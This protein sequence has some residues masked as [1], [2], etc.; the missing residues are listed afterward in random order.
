MQYQWYS[1]D[2]N[3]E[4]Y[5]QG[6]FIEAAVAHYRATQKIN[7]GSADP[8]LFNVAWSWADHIVS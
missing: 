1:N 2:D 7:D 3:H 5:C 6:H 4:L 8:R